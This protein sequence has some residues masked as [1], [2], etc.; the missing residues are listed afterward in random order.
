MTRSIRDSPARR[1]RRR[2]AHRSTDSTGELL[3][4]HQRSSQYDYDHASPSPEPTRTRHRSERPRKHRPLGSQAGSAFSNPL[5]ANSLAQLDALNEKLGWSKHGGMREAP[6]ELESIQE[7]E[8]KPR[9]R[10]DEEKRKYEERRRER[11]RRTEDLGH[12][13]RH[14]ENYHSQRDYDR[15]DH[16]HHRKKRRIFSGP[17][18]EEG[19]EAYNEKYK[20]YEYR[21]DRAGPPSGSEDYDEEAARRKRRRLCEYMLVKFFTFL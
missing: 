12:R 2:R 3:P 4:R 5:S 16:N 10:R 15:S 21:V 9:K 17:Y 19:Q 6:E 11:R 14:R 18:L 8:Y 1:D 13:E 7:K 20:K